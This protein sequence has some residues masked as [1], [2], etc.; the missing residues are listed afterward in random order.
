MGGVGVGGLDGFELPFLPFSLNWGEGSG[1]VGQCLLL[2][3]ETR[4][5][6]GGSCGLLEPV[7]DGFSVCRGARKTI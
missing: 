5:V 7:L 3:I 2:N 6:Y 1:G 4:H